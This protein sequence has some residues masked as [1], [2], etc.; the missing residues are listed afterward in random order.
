[1]LAATL[2]S[3]ALLAPAP[4]AAAPA[5]DHDDRAV[6]VRLRAA[7]AGLDVR[8]ENRDGYDR[9]LFDH[10]VDAD[11]DCR[12]TRDEVLAQESRI[13]VGP[14]CDVSE[15]RWRSY[16]DGLTWTDSSDVDIDHMVALAEAWDSGARGWNENTRRRFA[17]DLREGRSLVAVTDNVNQSKSDQDVAEWLP[18]RRGTWCRYIAEWVV[19]KTRWSLTVDRPE[20]R[21]LREL[22]AD[23][24]NVRL[25]IVRAPIGHS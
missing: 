22:A 17:N 2:L 4:T 7:V 23:C 12:D 16:Y 19:V 9:D 8:Q 1:M 15:D 6:T 20:K 24:P 13:A 11:G 14:G 3:S 21:R 18:P 5:P 10:W 25:R